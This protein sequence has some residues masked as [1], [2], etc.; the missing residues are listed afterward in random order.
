[1]TS[2]LTTDH[3]TTDIAAR[4]SRRVLQIMSPR[5]AYRSQRCWRNGCAW[6]ELPGRPV[7]SRSP[8]GDPRSLVRSR[9]RYGAA[10]LHRR[11]ASTAW[12]RRDLAARRLGLTPGR[13][14]RAKPVT[15]A[16]GGWI[17]GYF[18]CAKPDYI[19][20]TRR[21]H[22]PR[23]NR[24]DG[25]CLRVCSEKKKTGVFPAR[26]TRPSLNPHNKNLAAG[27]IPAPPRPRWR[28]TATTYA[29]TNTNRNVA[30]PCDVYD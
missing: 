20:A 13:P 26:P 22:P 15:L 11:S 30:L 18:S 3:P 27:G 6:K 10:R 24:S 5:W 19:G 2:Q 29:A 1:M 7:S 28:D 9:P 16:V 23:G 17:P 14:V 12:C 25:A 21:T 8:G 4:C